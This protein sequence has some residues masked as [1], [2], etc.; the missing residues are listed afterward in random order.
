MNR[1][2]DPQIPANSISASSDA[3]QTKQTI[4]TILLFLVLAVGLYLTSLYSYLLF[5][6]LAE[7]VSIAISLAVFLLVWNARSYLDNHYL[8]FLGIGMLFVVIVTIVHTLA[9]KGMGVFVGFDS[10]LPTSLWIISRYMMALTFLAALGFVYRKLQPAW[11][12]LGYAV[13]TALLFLTVFVWPVFPACY[14]EGSGLTPFKVISEYVISALF[15]L[16]LAGLWRVRKVF[17]SNTVRL[18]AGAL[19]ISVLSELAFTLYVGVYSIFNLIGHLLLV[20]SCLLIY[21]AVVVTGMRAPYALIYRNLMQREEQ[22]HSLFTYMLEGFSYCRLVME[23]DQP[24]DWIHLEVNQAFERLTGLADVTG[25]RASVAIPGIQ[26][27]DP[28]LLRIYSRVALSGTPERFEMFVQSL[29]MWFSVS[30]YSPKKEYFVAVF[31]I[32]TERKRA[33]EKNKLNESRLQELLSL[34]RLENRTEESVLDYA[35]DA[36]VRLLQSQ[37]AYVG[38]V[39]GDQSEMDIH[40]WSK[41]VMDRCAVRGAP[42]HFTIA[43]AGL[44]GEVIRRR[45]PIMIND[46]E[47]T[48]EKK[49]GFPE[50]HV[51]IRNFLSVPIF[52]AGKIVAIAAVANKPAPYDE[53]DINT[54]SVVLHEMWELKERR[55]SEQVLRENEEQLKLAVEGSGV[56]LWDWHVQTGELV[57]SERLVQIVGYTL[58]DLAPITEETWS[59][60]VHPDDLQ[61]S[62]ELLARHFAREMPAYQCEVRMRHKDG[63]WVWVL[64]RGKVTEWNPQH[65]VV[66]ITGTCLD[67]SDRKQAEEEL[68]KARADFLFGVSHELK[69]PLFVMRESLAML[70]QFDQPERVEK[71]P[72]FIETWQRNLHRLQRLIDN[73]LD[74]QRS[75]NKGFTLSL[76][77]TNLVELLQDLLQEQEIPARQKGI[78]FRL[79]TNPL[80]LMSL[81]QEAVHRMLENLLS[82]AIKFS[83]AGGDVLIRLQREQERV[84]LSIIDQGP[85]IP[86]SQQADLFQPF[87]RARAADEA[88]IPGTGLGLYVSKSIAEAHGGTISLESEPG[89]GATVTILLP[90]VR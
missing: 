86:H 26:E 80:P 64:D 69:T 44:S 70:E 36:I 74:S 10:N 1:P 63:H 56:G 31:D 43:N 77:P 33:E 65:Q 32:I 2:I 79:E 45:Q 17:P 6:S 19:L 89:K 62:N 51:L 11:V 84:K 71:L 30:V 35:L 29:Q 9:Y 50:G 46:Y 60:L 55:R 75:A 18:L 39:S 58:E 16:S 20:F 47:N 37:F 67:I 61:C 12:F 83:P 68:E 23:N 87:R 21:Q 8:L 59:R 49:S 53:T 13:I 81:D 40:A 90:L 27:A 4:V 85:G 38:F 78:R 7:M 3:K 15:L 25:K 24:R 66:R 52:S 41:G 54:L 72:N 88:R 57:Y 42:M 14:V 22:Y 82:N 34:H 76:Q 28:E 48:K 73:L 5:H